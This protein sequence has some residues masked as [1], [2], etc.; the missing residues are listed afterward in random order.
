MYMYGTKPHEYVYTCISIRLYLVQ[1]VEAFVGQVYKEGVVG[2]WTPLVVLGG[3]DLS[4]SL[5]VHIAA[6]GLCTQ[7]NATL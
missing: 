7:R 2:N 4:T 5:Y 3:L 6:E 1:C